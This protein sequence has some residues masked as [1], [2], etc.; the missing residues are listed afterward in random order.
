MRG[1]EISYP[2]LG[3][4][5]TKEENVELICETVFRVPGEKSFQRASDPGWYGKGVYFSEY[6]RYSMKY[7]KDS[8]RLLLCQILPE[9]KLQERL[10]ITKELKFT[11]NYLQH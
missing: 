2:V 5:G 9:Q 7:I 11:I 8:E 6:P 1:K 4:H 10:S 3:F